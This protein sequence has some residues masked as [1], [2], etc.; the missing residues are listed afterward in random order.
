MVLRSFSG[1]GQ[2]SQR[3]EEGG[4]GDK[5]EESGAYV[6]VT[7]S[8]TVY[9]V[10]ANCSYIRLSVEKVKSGGI[11]DRRN[12]YGGKYYPCDGCLKKNAAPETV[13]YGK[14]FGLQ[15]REHI[16]MRVATVER[17]RGQSKKY[18]FRKLRCTGR[19]AGVQK[20]NNSIIKVESWRG[21][22]GR[23]SFGYTGLLWDC[24][25]AQEKS[26]AAHACSGT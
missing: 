3:E 1:E 26:F 15:R 21:Y 7:E 20:E 12:Q 11:A 16:T 6:Y 23:N 22:E 24:G 10:L 19:V 13:L 8:G 4:D 5:E 25:Y 9:H 18:H 14:Q 17:S 2:L